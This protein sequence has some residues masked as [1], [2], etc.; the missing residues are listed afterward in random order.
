M[1]SLRPPPFFCMQ[2]GDGGEEEVCLRERERKREK[3]GG[4]ER[5]SVRAPSADSQAQKTQGSSA[6][7]PIDVSP[8]S[9]ER[10]GTNRHCAAGECWLLYAKIGE[11]SE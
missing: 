6:R 1:K 8:V 5:G 10:A 4:E 11:K 7:L 2:G 9:H 3:E